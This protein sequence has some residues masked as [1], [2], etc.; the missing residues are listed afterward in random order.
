MNA[1]GIFMHLARR[2]QE[3]SWKFRYASI[4][5]LRETGGAHAWARTPTHAYA[6]Q[7]T[8]LIPFKP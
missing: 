2:M 5:D 8:C 6:R 1:G 3:F 7:N 4:R